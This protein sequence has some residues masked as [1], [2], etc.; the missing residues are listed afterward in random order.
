MKN[1]FVLIICLLSFWS[2]SAQEEAINQH[3]L[4]NPVMLNPAAAGFAELHQLQVNARVTW[5]GFSNAPK[6]YSL[7][8]NGP[9]GNAFGVGLNVQSDQAADLIN[10]RVQ[11]NFGFR[12]NL[13]DNWKVATGFA[14]ELR[15][16]RLT[17]EAVAAATVQ[18][19]DRTIGDYAN[20]R[21]TIDA[22]LGLYTSYESRGGVTFA[23]LTFNNLVRNRLDGI[24][25]PD[26]NPSVFQYYTFV[27]GH[28]FELY[29]L[30]AKLEPSL[31]IRQI[32]N[33]TETVMMDFNLKARFLEDQLIAGLSYR[34][35]G[36]MGILLGTK[37]EGLDL[38]YSYDVSF[39]D[40]QQYHSGAHEVTIGIT[41]GNTDNRR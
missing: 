6:T 1:L 33:T 27:L 17:S 19:G 20:G 31:A 39:Q 9:I 35:L 5:T 28:E 8:Y 29:D 18:G 26:E 22:T 37:L 34:T 10:N 15:Q 41:F 4:I 32:R 21:G 24:V 7:L 23:G 40:S 2:L 14:A 3:Y 36:I 38:Y 30:N 12:F 25:T 13:Q 16:A 11:L